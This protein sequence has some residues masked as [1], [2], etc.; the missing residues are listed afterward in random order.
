[1]ST[2]EMTSSSEPS[3]SSSSATT[4]NGKEGWGWFVGEEDIM[5]G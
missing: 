1:M 5:F 4:S 2:T 3:S